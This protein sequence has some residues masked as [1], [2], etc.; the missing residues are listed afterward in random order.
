M[1]T[2]ASA[3]VPTDATAL[4]GAVT[5]DAITDH[6]AERQ[7]GADN[8]GDTRASGTLD[9]DASVDYL[10]DHLVTAGYQVTRQGIERL[11]MQKLSLDALAREHLERA[12]QSSAGR[13]AE[14]VFGG[15][16]HVLRQTLVA[17]RAGTVLGEHE[18]P[19]ESTVHVLSGRVR[20]SAGADSW[21]GRDGDLLVVPPARHDLQA[22]EDAVVVLTVAMR[23]LR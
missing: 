12:R 22:V 14:T 20:L 23:G 17:L 4:R 11:S 13:S 9:Y 5:S 16:E 21:D 8:N 19:G 3:A 7:N 1:A 6:L 18:N 15:H 10:E 2:S